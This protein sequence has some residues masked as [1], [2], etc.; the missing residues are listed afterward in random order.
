VPVGRTELVR[1]SRMDPKTELLS[2]LSEA[3]TRGQDGFTEEDLSL[4]FEE[5]LVQ[6]QIGELIVEGRLDLRIKDGTVLYSATEGGGVALSA[7]M[8]L[9]TLIENV[10]S[11]EGR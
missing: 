1:F 2:R 10:R 6:S 11:A 7:P 9:E 3:L 5:V 8:P 4:A